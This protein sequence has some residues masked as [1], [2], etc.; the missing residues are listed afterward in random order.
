MHTRLALFAVILLL[1][2]P[3][4]MAADKLL[5]R[6]NWQL[7]STARVKD[8]GGR[9]SSLSYSPAGWYK[10]S[11]PSTVLAALV[12]NK[13]YPDPFFDLNLK[14]IPGYR[15]GRWLVMPDGS[16]F[17]MAW[18]YRTEFT[19]P[20]SAAGR[21]VSL[22]L[23]GINYQADVWLNGKKIADRKAVIGMFRRFEFDVTKVVNVGK[24]NVLAVEITPP[25]L[26][27]DIQYRTK[28]L[29][30]TTGWD[31]HNPQPPDLNMGIWRN[32]Y[33]RTTGPVALK[34][35]YV[36]SKLDLPALDKAHL[37]VPV[38]VENKTDD[39]VR[40]ELTLAIENLRFSKNV[41][42]SPQHT[43]TV[44]FTP[45]EFKQLNISQP[46]VW[47]PNPLGKQE[48]YNAKLQFVADG[49]ASDTT[50]VRFGIREA[51]SYINEE[52]WRGYRV[53]GHNVLI[54]GGAW[55]SADML[56]RLPPK[57]YEALLRYT[58]EANLNMLRSEGFAARETDEFYD[59][60]DELGIMVTQQI[61]GR[62]LPDE[63]LAIANI[64]DMLLRIRNHPSLVH[65]LG[66][67]ETFP[68]PTLDQAYREMITKYTPERTY[69]PHS[70][71]FDVKERF[72]TGGTRT[73][74][75]ELW[76]YATPGK[77][78]AGKE[79]GAW[80]F[81]QSGGIGGVFAPMESLKRMLK[82]E[83]MSAASEA[84]SL[85]TVIQGGAYFSALMRALERRY[86]TPANFADL[87][88]KGQALNYESA[89]GMYEAYARNKYSALG[90][91]AWKYDASWP[92][93]LTWQYVD[94][95]GIAGGAYY[96]AKKANEALHVQYS[97]DDRSIWV[98]NSY[99]RDFKGLG[100]SA[101][102]YNLD[103]SEKYS[104][105]ASVDVG[106]D[107][108]TR[109]FA[110]DWPK[111]LSKTHFLRLKLLDGSGQQL[112]DNLY[113]L[114]T[115]PD[116][117]GKQG[118][119]SRSENGFYIEPKSTMDFTG[120][121]KLPAVKLAVTS[122]FSTEQKGRVGYVTVANPANAPAFMVQLA[123][124][125]GAGGLEVTPCFWEDNYFTLLPGE[126]KQVR[127]TLAP[128]DLAGASPVVRVEGWN[129]AR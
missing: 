124:T 33:I 113:W 77:Y 125:R 11:I 110:I 74:T 96:G 28:Q 19:L 27:P 32:V 88:R 81:A 66:H 129:V 47:W 41:A 119:T 116:T 100:V 46:R 68:T 10:T 120:L 114:S 18:W 53:N 55:M 62:N 75:R 60:C 24:K 108:K 128:E 99:Y 59:L 107:G 121:A 63:R 72:K 54:R 103:M 2:V 29:E 122:G 85:H 43:E 49:E 83:S 104:R 71:A 7:Q 89:R 23:D 91:T 13:V 84:W 95:Y 14:S 50:E 73:G 86:G 126:K 34:N 111:D 42:V 9:I 5:L 3:A 16:P 38:D 8:L 64:E 105:E 117:P 22:N 40:G 44:R 52:G 37:T 48:L 97:Y 56:M 51:T 101:K 39:E 80:G 102:I 45:E 78:Y 21:F 1:A 112:S 58:R 106:P 118:Y 12:E 4:T 35:P 17:K 94:W 79:D 93:A 26:L 115:V 87:I 36:S 70:G 65:F 30:A 76:T 25:G 69:Q 6:D 15:E 20:A 90:I 98:V 109:A 127:V 31:D 61:F 67:D 57:R 82:P 123:I 92:A